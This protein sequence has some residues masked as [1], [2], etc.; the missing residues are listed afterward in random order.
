VHRGFNR[1]WFGVSAEVIARVRNSKRIVIT[2][3]S[4][5]GD[6]GI[7]CAAHLRELDLP[8]TDVI[9]FGAARIGNAAFRDYYNEE[10]HDVT[11]RFEAQGDPVPW[12]PPW[13]LNSYRHVGRCAYL[14]NDGSVTIDPVLPNL[15]GLAQAV[16]P[17][18]PRTQTQDSRFIRQMAKSHGVANYQRL[19]DQLE[20]TA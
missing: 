4:K 2:G 15:P 1:G 17:L 12:L 10:L 18:Q 19:F 13:L 16:L 9:T 8:V 11:L 6:N 3:H 14:K 7:L 20:A 5:G